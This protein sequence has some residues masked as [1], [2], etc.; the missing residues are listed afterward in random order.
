MP[1]IYV[2][3]SSGTVTTVING[4]IATL[5]LNI[6]IDATYTLIEPENMFEQKF[7]FSKGKWVYPESETQEI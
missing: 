2:L 7:D 3:D 4:D 6:P 5:Q 1:A